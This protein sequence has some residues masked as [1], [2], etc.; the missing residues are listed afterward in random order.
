MKKSTRVPSEKQ[1]IKLLRLEVGSFRANCYLVWDAKGNCV[2]I[3]AGEDA[4]FIEE[5][6][7]ELRLAPKI[8]LAT[9]GHFDHLTAVSSLSLAYSIPLY[10]S[11]KDKFLFKNLKEPPPLISKNQQEGDEVK[12]GDIFLQVLE[13][14][15]HTPGSLA[16]KLKNSPYV[17]CGDVFFADGSL[18]RTDFGYS[19]KGTLQKSILKLRRL[20]P[21]TIFC[22]GHA[23]E[24]AN[25]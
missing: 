16:Y 15:G 25:L 7:R 19:D 10:M 21:K 12:V 18:G 20:S 23:E 24:F 1:P 22:P 11:N 17:F 14:P 6:I 8:I 5:K 4:E 2:I 3:D 13:V 9:H